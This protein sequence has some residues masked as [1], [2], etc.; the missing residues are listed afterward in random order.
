MDNTSNYSNEEIIAG[1]RSS[2][3]LVLSYIYRTCYPVIERIILNEYRGSVEQAKDV[4]QD[5]LLTLFTASSSDPPLKITHSFITYLTI[6]CKRRMIDEIRENKKEFLGYDINEFVDDCPSI[7][8]YMQEEDRIRI[9]EKHFQELG[10][11]CREL[12]TL[13]LEGHTVA[14]IT[15]M[16]SMSSEQFTKNR[17]LKCKRSLFKRIYDD[18]TLK[19]LINGK[20]WTIREIPKW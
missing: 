9:Y 19:E 13:F 20:P 8:D 5:A 7:I 3:K 16:L 1:I 17:R 6:I 2:D 15:T 18:P 4:F 12:L 11:K 14:A 10:E